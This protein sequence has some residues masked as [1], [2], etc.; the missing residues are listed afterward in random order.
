M[1]SD[2]I[3]GPVEETVNHI[4]SEPA[5]LGQ[6]FKGHLIQQVEKQR[7]VGAVEGR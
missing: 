7:P 3:G 2:A 6:P 4:G 5:G 1:L